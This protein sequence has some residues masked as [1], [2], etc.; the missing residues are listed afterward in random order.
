MPR[1]HRSTRPVNALAS[2]ASLKGVLSAAE[3]A[4]ALARGFRQAG[5][6]AI[7]AAVRAGLG[8]GPGSGLGIALGAA[9]AVVGFLLAPR[10]RTT[11]R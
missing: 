11:V 10:L 8:P 4:A 5:A 6:G 2:P 9:L 1:W 3:A 7:G